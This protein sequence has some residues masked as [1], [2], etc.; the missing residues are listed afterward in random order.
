MK[1]E[2]DGQVLDVQLSVNASVLK[3]KDAPKEGPSKAAPKKPASASKKRKVRA[4]AL[5]LPRAHSRQVTLTRHFPSRVLL[6]WCRS[7]KRRQTTTLRRLQLPKMM[8]KTKT[9]T[10][11]R[12]RTKNNRTVLSAGGRTTRLSAPHAACIVGPR[13]T[14]RT[15]RRLPAA[16]TALFRRNERGSDHFFINVS[17][18]K[19]C[20]HS[21]NSPPI[22]TPRC[23]S[24]SLSRTV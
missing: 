21:L 22:G 20:A 14:C 18:I 3:S 17:A 2:V 5:L 19:V 8:R 6:G 13:P 4:L 10:N 9:E 1:I 15:T 24:S 16:E 12:T 11:T 7:M 23:S